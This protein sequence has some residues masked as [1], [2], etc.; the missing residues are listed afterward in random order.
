MK[1]ES[2]PKASGHHFHTLSIEHC[3]LERAQTFPA[4]IARTSRYCL[5][6]K[7]LSFSVDVAPVKKTPLN[8][9]RVH[10]PH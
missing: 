9:R 5:V 7:F 1:R 3:V 10:I 2:Y 6:A 4:A 8:A